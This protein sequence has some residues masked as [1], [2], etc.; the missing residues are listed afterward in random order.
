MSPLSPTGHAL[1]GEPAGSVE[2]TY[3]V[4]AAARLVIPY[5]ICRHH[6]PGYLAATAASWPARGAYVFMPNITRQIT[7]FHNLPV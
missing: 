1:G 2:L 6:S 5:A 4:V 7:G 3:A